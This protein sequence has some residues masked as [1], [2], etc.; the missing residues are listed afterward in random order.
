ME[1]DSTSTTFVVI[2]S[3]DAGFYKTRLDCLDQNEVTSLPTDNR[4][5]SLLSDE[6][7]LTEFTGY[8]S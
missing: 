2:E 6:K 7:I 8:C 4:K 3:K 1:L 5:Y